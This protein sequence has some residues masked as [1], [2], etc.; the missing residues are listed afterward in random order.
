M[1][2]NVNLILFVSVFLFFIL[3][4]LMLWGILFEKSRSTDNAAA[5][6]EEFTEGGDH[7]AHANDT[8]AG[9]LQAV[10]LPFLMFPLTV[11][12]HQLIEALYKAI[13]RS[14]LLRTDFIGMASLLLAFCEIL[15]GVFVV[16]WVRRHLRD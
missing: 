5:P 15:L 1:V 2:T 7:R 11:L 4:G 16:R 12:N 13:G 3:P 6:I 9:C 14:T 10:L 8:A